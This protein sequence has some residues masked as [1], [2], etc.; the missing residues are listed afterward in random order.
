MRPQNL[1][2]C[3]KMFQTQHSHHWRTI[4]C[5]IAGRW[6]FNVSAN[7]SS[8][9]KSINCFPAQ[10]GSKSLHDFT[11]WLY[12]EK[13]FMIHLFSNHLKNWN[14]LDSPEHISKTSMAV[15]LKLEIYVAYNPELFVFM[16]RNFLVR[17]SI[18]F[19]KLQT[20]R[21]F[22]EQRDL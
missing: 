12:M 22:C 16:G 9:I 7:L 8:I 4:L 1:K 20:R 17:K 15:D 19:I 14:E 5:N 13:F 11:K 18:Q 6:S 10:H 2:K 3:R 21:L